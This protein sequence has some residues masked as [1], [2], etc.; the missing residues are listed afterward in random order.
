MGDDSRA[1]YPPIL[2]MAQNDFQRAVDEMRVSDA[3]VVFGAAASFQA[4][5]PLGG[6]L[7]PLVWHTLDAH[8]SVLRQVA[9]VLG[10]SLVDPA[11]I[12]DD[13]AAAARG[14]RSACRPVVPC[15]PLDELAASRYAPAQLG[16]CSRFAQYECIGID[17][18]Q[19]HAVS[20]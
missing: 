6:Q 13:L 17:R 2:N 7:P 12:A 3:I 1:R 19:S 4:G 16:R 5:M 10:L 8:P 18:N 14:R 15:F 20:S 9:T 11:V